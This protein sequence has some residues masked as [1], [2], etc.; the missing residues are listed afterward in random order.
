M[1]IFQDPVQVASQQKEQKEIDSRT[2]VN[3]Q[4]TLYLDLSPQQICLILEV[5]ITIP[6]GQFQ[7]R[8]EAFFETMA[9]DIL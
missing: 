4:Q 3:Q 2:I 1:V 9:I 6:V 7:T 8:L 5:D